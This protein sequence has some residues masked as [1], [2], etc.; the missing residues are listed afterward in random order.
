MNMNNIDYIR[1]MVLDNAKKKDIRKTKFTTKELKELSEEDFILP[2]GH[3]Y[4]SKKMLLFYKTEGIK[5][6]ENEKPP[7]IFYKDQL[8]P[9][10]LYEDLS[11]LIQD[12]SQALIDQRERIELIRQ[13]I[14]ESVNSFKY[15]I[16]KIR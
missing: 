1:S 4:Y 14:K 3:K 8:V 13:D 12:L 11:N 10:E 16:N 15:D 5:L 2:R 7:S 6:E 9:F